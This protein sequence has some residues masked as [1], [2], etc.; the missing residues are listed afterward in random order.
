MVECTVI[1]LRKE[2]TL[3]LSTYGTRFSTIHRCEICEIMWTL[4]N[5][6]PLLSVYKEGLKTQGMLNRCV[7][8]GPVARLETMG[9]TV[10]KTEHYVSFPNMYEH[11]Q[12]YNGLPLIPINVLCKAGYWVT[13]ISLCSNVMFC[14]I[15]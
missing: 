3:L 9:I 4:T 5:K 1:L 10:T 6:S 13:V 8:K 2:D 11:Y 12:W 14:N 7:F 15:K